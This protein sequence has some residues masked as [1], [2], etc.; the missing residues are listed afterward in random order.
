[1]PVSK[2]PKSNPT[3]LLPSTLTF[4]DPIPGILPFGGVH[5]FGGASGIGKTTVDAPLA[6]ALRDGTPYFGR[7]T[8][9]VT[10]V[11]Y[12]A[13][14]RDWRTYATKFTAVGFPDIPHYCLPDDRTEI[15][16]ARHGR[17]QFDLFERCMAKL[18][19]LPGAFVFVDPVAP[20]FVRGDQNHAWDAATAMHHFRWIAGLYHVTLFC[21]SNVVKER[22]D[23]GF[24]RAR[25]RISGSGALGAYSD[26]QWYLI[27]GQSPTRRVLG[28]APREEAEVEY[29]V[30]FNA[31]THL[32]EYESGPWDVGLAFGQS[33]DLDAKGREREL[34]DCIAY[35]PEDTPA[36][37]IIEFAAAKEIS[38]RTTFRYLDILT[39]QMSIVKVAKGRYQ[40]PKTH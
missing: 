2:H 10:A 33:D 14:D 23:A 24:T 25:D 9:K 12:L 22:T 34:L 21:L 7:D 6:V 18:A 13:A 1:M 19:P 39:D 5:L 17:G 35:A 28:W 37:D 32:Y 15:P 29:V 40:R 36:E 3:P 38:R 16:K 11:Y 20:T 31:H 30:R 8:N 26:T 4:P 27:N